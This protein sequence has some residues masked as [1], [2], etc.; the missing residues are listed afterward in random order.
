MKL[1]IFDVDGT[2]TR[3]VEVD[4][5][6][7][8]QAFAD[9]FKITGID[10]DWAG[11]ENYT[12]SGIA[13]EIFRQKLGRALSPEEHVKL[14]DRF[15]FLLGKSA[16][17]SPELFGEIPG[18]NKALRL[19]EKEPDWKKAIATGCWL[20]SALFK[21][22]KAGIRLKEIPVASADDSMIREKIVRLCRKRARSL[23]RVRHFRR[24][25]Y[26]G[27]GIWDVR[28][29]ARLKIPFLAVAD[30]ERRKMLSRAGAAHFLPDFSDYE[31]F[32]R[33]LEEAVV[34]APYSDQ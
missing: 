23:Y 2:L 6:C 16:K 14:I 21:L 31:L 24:L 27:D 10:T 1:V 5:A 33:K 25:V 8:V 34:P 4:S 20:D 9:E 28:I 11:Y 7:F 3:T 18:A 17:T 15:L 22:E 29:C 19:L 30:G 12:D 26:V 13:D 32:L